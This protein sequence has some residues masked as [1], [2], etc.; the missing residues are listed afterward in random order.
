MS[1]SSKKNKDGQIMRKEFVCNKEGSNTKE[2][3]GDEQK[4]HGLT[5]EGCKARLV[6]VRS[7][8]GGYAVRD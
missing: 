4:R 5:K 6:V 2:W 3:I 1:D 8:L 7:K